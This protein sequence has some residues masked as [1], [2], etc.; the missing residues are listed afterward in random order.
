MI[1]SSHL[2][3]RYGIERGSIAQVRPAVELRAS[4][5]I[6]SHTS[7]KIRESTGKTPSER[8]FVVHYNRSR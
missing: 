2:K 5:F 8:L 7:E 4:Y 6:Q 1:K 3:D